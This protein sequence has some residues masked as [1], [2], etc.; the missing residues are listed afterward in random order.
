MTSYRR[1]ICKSVRWLPAS[2][3]S[4]CDVIGS[5]YALQFLIHVAHTYSLIVAIK[6]TQLHWCSKPKFLDQLSVYRLAEPIRLRDDVPVG[7]SSDTAAGDDWH[8]VMMLDGVWSM[9]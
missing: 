3:P 1:C 9:K 6:T 7:Q 2:L 8:S 5:L 4:A